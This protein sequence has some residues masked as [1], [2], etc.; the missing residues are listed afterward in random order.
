MRFFNGDRFQKGEKVSVPA[1]GKS[2]V[3]TIAV[4]GSVP[5]NDKW[6]VYEW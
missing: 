4:K 6:A 5:S 2:A 1:I 3:F